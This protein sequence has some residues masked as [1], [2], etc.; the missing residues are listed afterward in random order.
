MRMTVVL[1]V[2]CPL[3]TILKDLEKRAEIEG[4][5]GTNRDNPDYCIV[6]MD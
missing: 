5:R 1:F 4:N 2:N 3:G 6:G